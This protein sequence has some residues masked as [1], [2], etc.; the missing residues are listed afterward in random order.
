[1]LPIKWTKSALLNQAETFLYWN[2]RNK[3]TTY[4]KKIRREIGITEKYIA[5]NP[6]AGKQSEFEN[7]RSVLILK[8]FSIFY[9]VKF[10][11]IEIVAFWDNRRNP[12]N[13]EI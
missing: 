8:N 6:L 10:N 12:E 11:E 13:L 1:M 3:S 9:R 2:K 4:S 5:E 7:V